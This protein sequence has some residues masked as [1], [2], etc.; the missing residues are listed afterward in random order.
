LTLGCAVL[1]ALVGGPVVLAITWRRARRLERELRELRGEV[2]ALRAEVGTRASP[3]RASQPQQASIQPQQASIQPLQAPIQPTQAPL[4]PPQ[5]PAPVVPSVAPVTSARPAALVPPQTERMARPA[6]RPAPARIPIDWER[7]IGVR[8]AAVVGGIFL[9]LAAIF[10]FKHAFTQG[11]IAPEARVLAGLAGGAAAIL[12]AARLRRRGYAWATS[13]LEGAGVVALYASVWAADELYSLISRLV[14]FPAMAAITALACALAMRSGSLFTAL[15]ALAGGFLTPL[16]LAEGTVRTVPLFAYLLLLDVGLLFVARRRAWPSLALVALVATFAYEAWAILAGG[17]RATLGLPIGAIFAL[18]FALSGARMAQRGRWLAT[19]ALGV[20]LALVFALHYAGEV[21]LGAHVWP[22]A[23]L[24]ALLVI[25]AA[26]V[27]RQHEA[28][29]LAS[30]APLASMGVFLLWV[31]ELPRRHAHEFAWELALVGSGLAFVS[32]AL[33]EWEHARDAARRMWRWSAA[34]ASGAWAVLLL[35]ALVSQRLQAFPASFMALLVVGALLLRLGALLASAPVVWA[36]GLTLGV[37]LGLVHDGYDS[38]MESTLPDPRLF[39]VVP[40]SLASALLFLVPRHTPALAR[41]SRQAACLLLVGCAQVAFL[42]DGDD[43]L[44]PWLLPAL[45]VPFG[46]LVLWAAARLASGAW[47]AASVWTTLILSV[48]YGWVLAT[49]VPV[50]LVRSTLPFVLAGPA[51]VTL[52]AAFLTELRARRWAWGFLAA[53]T[54]LSASPFAWLYEAA[55]GTLFEAGPWLLVGVPP[56]LAAWILLARGAPRHA[57]GWMAAAAALAW[58]S[59]VADQFDH[60]EFALSCSLFA[61][62]LA[63]IARRLELGPA[64]WAAVASALLGTLVLFWMGLDRWQ[65]PRSERIVWNWVSYA[66]LV[67]AAALGVVLWRLPT[68]AGRVWHARRRSL[69]AACVLGLVFL[70]L[71]LLIEN[72]FAETPE[73]ALFAAKGHARDLTTSFGWGLYALVL[74]ALG[75]ARRVSPLRWASLAVFVLTIGKVF[76][77]DLAHLDGLYRVASLAGLALSLIAVS[78]SYQRFV[79]RREEREAT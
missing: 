66:H 45:A 68:S 70:W 31:H 76:L 2:R 52:A 15:L 62:A 43:D 4:Q 28:S 42:G 5:A 64:A 65:Y 50:E 74:L 12:A 38:E 23:L 34:S 25:A 58:T 61:A 13:A 46:L 72:A 16:L 27:A 22:T 56:A 44:H 35:L 39:W 48:S 55:F 19:Q 6:P 14:S 53:L 18:L 73:L 10:F 29:W 75:T 17:E 78:L 7:W 21:A 1:A 51:A 36:A 69:L 26:L 32:H 47:V 9:A 24:L 77:H 57:V 41:A 30:A 49:H 60:A 54:P 33:A 3:E 71:N 20:L 63:V 59:G 8:G 40:L 11:W 37:G 79:F 67:P